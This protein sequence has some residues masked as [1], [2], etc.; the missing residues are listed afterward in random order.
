MKYNNDTQHR[1]PFP[2][3]LKTEKTE[4]SHF[5]IMFY[6]RNRWRYLL[7]ILMTIILGLCSRTSYIPTWI[8]PYLGDVLYALMI[9]WGIAFLYP[10]ISILKVGIISYIICI[11]IETSQLYQ[12]DWINELRAT[13]LGSL[14]LG[15]GFLWSDW[16]SYF[17]GCF[18][19]VILETLLMKT[20][21]NDKAQEL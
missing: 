17:I 20:N 15:H 3:P 18:W 5:K 14:T 11:L 1:Q 6:Q 21:E 2:K 13:T 8:Y 10:K 4:N 7:Y 19:G 16:L 12:A 9:Y